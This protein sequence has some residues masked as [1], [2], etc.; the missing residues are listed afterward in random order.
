MLARFTKPSPL[1]AAG[2]ALNARLAQQTRF[3]ATVEGSVG[4]TMPART[5]RATPVS[6]DRAT[7]TIRVSQR[8]ARWRH[9][10]EG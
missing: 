10:D 5:P 3:L 9:E 1:K 7:L 8:A 2:L 4:R 6:H